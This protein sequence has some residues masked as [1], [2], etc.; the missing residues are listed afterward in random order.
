MGKMNRVVNVDSSSPT[1]ERFRKLT[2][3]TQPT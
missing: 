3:F 1:T 2:M